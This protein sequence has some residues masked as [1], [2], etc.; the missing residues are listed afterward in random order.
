MFRR[1]FED[2]QRKHSSRNKLYK[3]DGEGEKAKEVQRGFCCGPGERQGVPG[4]WMCLCHAES[5]YL[6]G[7]LG[8]SG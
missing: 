4:S 1:K 8:H 7:D 2:I 6:V 5:Q 3:V